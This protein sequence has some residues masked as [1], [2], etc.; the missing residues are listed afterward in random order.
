MRRVYTEKELR[1]F[2]IVTKAAFAIL[3]VMLLLLSII[4]PFLLILSLASFLLAFK[5]KA[6]NKISEP[7]KRE[8]S[9]EDIREYTGSLVN[10]KP[11][12]YEDE[13]GLGFKVTARIEGAPPETFTTRVA[14]VTHNNPDGTSRQKLIAEAKCG[15]PVKL[16]REKDNQWDEFA[17]AVYD[18]ENRM[19]GYIP[20]GDVRLASHIDRG[21]EVKATVNKV[22]GGKGDKKTHGLVL[23][24][25]K[26]DFDWEVVRPYMDKDRQIKTLIEEAMATEK[27]NP[28]KSMEI[29]KEAIKKIIELDDM[30]DTSKAW[31][32]SRI[33]VDRLTL[34]L[35]RAGSLP[36]A[37]KYIQW[38]NSYDDHVGLTAGASRM[39]EKRAAR[40]EA[41]IQ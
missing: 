35:E 22:T 7:A 4:K 27:D 29:Y 19:L 33:P 2:T 18:K 6:K 8:Y 25:I 3:G 32:N 12:D 5:Y 41:K 40:L 38:Y 13:L 21:G 1:I 24:I 11:T 17:I 26:G 34:L 10:K 30:G 36:E 39:I 31:R 16:V 9:T 14:G 23:K 28:Q 20:A 37:Y 15:Q